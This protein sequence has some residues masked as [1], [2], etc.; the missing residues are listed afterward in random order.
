MMYEKSATEEYLIVSTKIKVGAAMAVEAAIKA[1]F[2]VLQREF[3]RL[4][5]KQTGP[6]IMIYQ[7]KGDYKGLAAQEYVLETAYPIGRG[8]MIK[9]DPKSKLAS[10]DLKKSRCA[11]YLFKGP[12]WETPWDEFIAAVKADGALNIRQIREVYRVFKGGGS[13]ENETELQVILE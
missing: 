8:K 10:R 1:N 5:V 9:I 3:P 7:F 13:P 2:E 11:S 12:V 6:V 4:N